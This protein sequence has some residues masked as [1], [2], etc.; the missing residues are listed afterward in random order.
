MAE[1]RRLEL[2]AIATVLLVCAAFLASFIFGLR[3]GAAPAPGI[4]EPAPVTVQPPAR[5]AGRVEVLNAS[6]RG[7]QARAATDQL[8][9]SGFDV[10]YFGNAPGAFGDSSVVIDRTGNDAVARAAA[11][12]LGISRVRTERD[13]TLYLDATVI[14]G[15]DW[16]VGQGN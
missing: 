5:A 11:R 6:G 14:V 4:G 16:V 15:V 12:R 7:G 8:R 13:T 1:R 2:V 9:S 10:V 3:G